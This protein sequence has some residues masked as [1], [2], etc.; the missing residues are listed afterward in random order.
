MPLI[1]SAMADAE[2]SFRVCGYP[3]LAYEMEKDS[4]IAMVRK[5]TALSNESLLYFQAELIALEK[6]LRDLQKRDSR[7]GPGMTPDVDARCAKDWEWLGVFNPDCQ[8]WKKVLRIREVLK[9]YST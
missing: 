3:R 5:F 1:E 8:Q 4:S 7:P 6:E 9:D 2:D